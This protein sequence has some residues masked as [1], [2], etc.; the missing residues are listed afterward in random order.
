MKQYVI[1]PDCHFP[2]HDLKFTSFITRLLASLK[3]S[4]KLKG[5]VQLGD[6]LD[7]FQISSYPKD[8]ARRNSIKD[9]MD[10]YA[11]IMN[12]WA[13]LLPKNGEFHQLEGN[14]EA[15]LQR[16]I[17]TNAKEI[18]ELVTSIGS[19]IKSKYKASAAFYW[20]PY[21]KWNSL[22]LGDVTLLHGFYYNQ[23][24]AATNLNKYK[25][26]IICGHTHRVQL[27]HDGVHYSAT[28]GHGSDE[29]ETAHQP[30]P[31]GWQQACGVLTVFDSGKTNFEIILV[32]QGKGFYGGKLI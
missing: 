26:S 20:H 28:L 24:T 5:I 10:D 31:T 15:R 12:E 23:H 14:H 21:K 16:Y 13:A 22:R 29:K 9:D 7:F 19:Y 8:P 30:T 11:G 4:G 3:A 27:I 6:A 32:N 18:H 2:Y 25:T 17:S 1:I